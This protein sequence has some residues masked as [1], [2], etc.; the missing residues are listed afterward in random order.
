M[1][2]RDLLGL[3]GMDWRVFAECGADNYAELD[4]ITGG[5]PSKVEL[6]T[7]TAAAYAM[8]ARCPVAEQ[9]GADA[10]QYQGEGVRA[11][12]LR[13]KPDRGQYFALPLIPQAVPSIYDVEQEVL[14]S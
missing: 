4:P 11:G 8:C 13:I 12:S 2:L 10:D 9:C 7:R 5:R 3:D 6:E 14:A 1:D